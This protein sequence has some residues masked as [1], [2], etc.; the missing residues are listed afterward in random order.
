MP[1]VGVSEMRGLSVV[2]AHF[3]KFNQAASDKFMKDL[4]ELPEP[5]VH[6]HDLAAFWAIFAVTG[7]SSVWAL[8]TSQPKRYSTGRP[9]VCDLSMLEI[10]SLCRDPD[11]DIPLRNLTLRGTKKPAS[12]IYPRGHLIKNSILGFFAMICVWLQRIGLTE[13]AIELEALFPRGDGFNPNKRGMTAEQIAKQRSR[14][15]PHGGRMREVKVFLRLPDHVLKILFKV[16]NLPLGEIRG[17]LWDLHQLISFVIQFGRLLLDPVMGTD[18]VG[19]KRNA[20]HAF[21]ACKRF[22]AIVMPFDV[23]ATIAENQDVFD[24]WLTRAEQIKL[25]EKI[26]FN[27]AET[28]VG[29][30]LHYFFEHACDIFLTYEFETA[31]SLMCEESAESIFLALIERVPRACLRRHNYV[32]YCTE[33]GTCIMECGLVGCPGRASVNHRY[34]SRTD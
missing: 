7:A 34:V 14:R 11:E 12:Y 15:P 31:K 22:V 21:L 18:W 3:G 2:G 13:L 30:P 6:Y 27:I 26:K 16:P 4:P 1:G 33:V 24:A 25:V 10:H 19:M 5:L 32:H 28:C 9:C 29:V 20:R 8:D 23:K 17:T